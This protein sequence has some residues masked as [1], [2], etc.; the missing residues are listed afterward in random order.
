MHEE[1][2]V[3]AHPDDEILWLSSVFEQVSQ[4]HVCFLDANGQLKAER[5][6][7]L[8]ELQPAFDYK[9]WGFSEPGSYGL[10]ADWRDPVMTPTGVQLTDPKIQKIY[11]RTYWDVIAELDKRI[12]DSVSVIYTHNPW[13]EYGHADHILVYRAVCDFVAQRAATGQNIRVVFSNYVSDQTRDLAKRII[14][15]EQIGVVGGGA[16]YLPAARSI[17]QVYMKHKCWTWQDADGK[18]VPYQW[19]SIELKLEKGAGQNKLAP[20]CQIVMPA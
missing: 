15:D 11:D 10:V 2:I 14:K 19:P 17:M 16:P 9:F 7:V 3:V 4:Y 5:R 13:G 1:Y 12:T 18:D 6:N 20:V 8:L